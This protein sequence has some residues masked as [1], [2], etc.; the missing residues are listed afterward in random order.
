MS[1]NVSSVKAYV[2]LTKPGIISGNIVTA[3]CGFALASRGSPNFFLLISMI[4]GLSCVIGAGC[5]INNWIDRDADSQMQRTKKRPLVQGHVPVLHALIFSLLLLTLGL[6]TLT[7]LTTALAGVVALIGFFAY[8]LWYSFAKYLTSYGTL[9]G[10][11]SGA[12][13]PVVGY[14]AVANQLDL[15][16]L[17]LF[18]IVVCWQMPHFY[19]ISLFRIG[20]YKAASIPVLPLVHG[21][22]QTKVQ[23]VVWIVAFMAISTLLTPIG[24]TNLTYMVMAFVLSIAWLIMC[25][26]GFKATSDKVWARKMFRFSLVVITL[27]CATLSFNTI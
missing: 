5:V 4:L 9:I 27:L 25:M 18:L 1:I 10:S 26:Q 20:E 12:V 3:A 23:M 11:V 16:A 6:V 14:A 8:V 17:M 24:Y 13:P 2:A 21:A 7:F 19:A 15:G 22:Q